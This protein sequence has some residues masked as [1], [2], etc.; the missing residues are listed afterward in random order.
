MNKIKILHKKDIWWKPPYHC[1]NCEERT[2]S[3]FG[4]EPQRLDI[5]FCSSKCHQQFYTAP[6]GKKE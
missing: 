5:A 3:G 4:T 2:G 1:W 6:I